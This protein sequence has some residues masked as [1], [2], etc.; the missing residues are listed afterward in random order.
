MLTR[1]P[2]FAAL[3]ALEAAARYLNFTRVAEELNVTQSAVGKADI[4]T[5]VVAGAVFI[6]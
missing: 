2:P 5:T 4:W 3:R 6:Q 1:N